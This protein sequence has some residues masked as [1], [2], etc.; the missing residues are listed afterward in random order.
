M[1][2]CYAPAVTRAAATRTARIAVLLAAMLAPSGAW[3]GRGVYVYVPDEG[4]DAAPVLRGETWTGASDGFEASLRLLDDGARRAFLE[5][6]TGVSTDPF[7]SR[8]GE[9]AGF[10]AFLVEIRNAGE[11][12]LLVQPHRCRLVIPHR[13]VLYP[14]D[15]AAMESAFTLLEREMPPAYRKAAGA[16]LQAE[17]VLPPGGSVSGLLVYRA[18]PAETRRFR[19]EVE[20]ATFAGRTAGIAAPYRR[21]RARGLEKDGR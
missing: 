9:P 6:R 5:N 10:L 11:D 12:D 15:F 21:R 17:T 18:V 8:P 4:A 1:S 14:L 19:V 7:L 2:L 13:D 20:V 16:L 3:G